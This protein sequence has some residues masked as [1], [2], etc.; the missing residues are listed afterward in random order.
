VSCQGAEVSQ[1][2]TIWLWEISSGTILQK[3]LTSPGATYSGV[4]SC[5]F[6][7][8]GS[9]IAAVGG[10]ELTIIDLKWDQ[11]IMS[12]FATM[13]VGQGIAYL[14]FGFIEPALLA[15]VMVDS[16]QGK[17]CLRPSK[18]NWRSASAWDWMCWDG[19]NI[20]YNSLSQ[21]ESGAGEWGEGGEAMSCLVETLNVF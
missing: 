20:T 5:A 8:D 9:R 14:D 19:C 13:S 4:H 1:G 11:P 10:D 2:D 18:E 3:F 17:H 6:S 7:P 12:N 16:Q 15:R 21:H